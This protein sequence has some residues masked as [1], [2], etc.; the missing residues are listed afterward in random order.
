MKDCGDCGLCCKLMGVTELAKPAGRWCGHFRR[1]VGCDAYD[2]RPASCRAFNCTWLLTDA[3]NEGWKPSVCG[4]LMHSDAGRLIVEC[5]PSRPQAWR[6]APYR[7]TLER[8]AVRGQEVL[9]FAGRRGLR[10]NPDATTT[11]LRRR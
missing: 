9:I 10:L 6:A 1:T 3:L 2:A 11:A 8:W 4:F 7:E 5:D